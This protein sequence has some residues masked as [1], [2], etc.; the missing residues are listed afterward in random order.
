MG[1]LPLHKKGRKVCELEN[2][3]FNVLSY[4]YVTIACCG[5]HPLSKSRWPYRG[6]IFSL[7]QHSVC[8]SLILIDL[9]LLLSS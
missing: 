5:S 8:L 1:G 9:L 3:D 2:K 6:C 4:Y 7:S